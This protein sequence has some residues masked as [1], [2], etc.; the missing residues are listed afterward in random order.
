MVKHRFLKDDYY[1]D[2]TPE[3]IVEARSA[4]QKM[5]NKSGSFNKAWKTAPTPE[6]VQELE[7]RALKKY[8]TG[9]NMK[10][11]GEGKEHGEE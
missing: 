7:D 2:N 8:G 6:R 11:H 9:H 10:V 3:E 5:A 4:M 1:M